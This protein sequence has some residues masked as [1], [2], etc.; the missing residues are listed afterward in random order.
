MKVRDAII[1]HPLLYQFGGIE[2]WIINYSQTSQIRWTVVTSG[3]VKEGTFAELRDLPVRVLRPALQPRKSDLEVLV[4]MKRLHDVHW[5]HDQA[6]VFSDDGM[7]SVAAGGAGLAVCYC[8]TP[9]RAWFDESVSANYSSALRLSKALGAQYLRRQW[10]QHYHEVVANSSE[11]KRRIVDAGLRN[12]GDVKVIYPGTATERFEMLPAPRDASQVLVF[13]RIAP[14]KNIELALEAFKCVAAANPKAHLVVAGGVSDRYRSYMLELKRRYG[15][16]G[17]VEWQCN[18]SQGGLEDALARATVVVV[19]SLNEDFGLTV[20]EALAAG[21]R[22]IA[23]RAGGPKEILEGQATGTLVEGNPREFG[24]AILAALKG[25]PLTTLEMELAR[26]RAR[27]FSVQES[28][29]R[30]D[31]VV[32]R[33]A[34]SRKMEL[35]RS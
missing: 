8:H 3:V 6:V 5:K 14:N 24:S 21:R 33:S 31:E 13:G 11:T 12:F 25:G 17:N 4:W 22:V 26:D 1:Y 35:P 9:P 7:T 32:T 27:V 19:P 23:V 16:L 15:E 20:I 10:R 28:T 18:L 29:R 34:E 2:R 30:L